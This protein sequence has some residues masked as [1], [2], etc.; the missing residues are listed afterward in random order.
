MRV[1]DTT[2]FIQAANVHTCNIK[3]IVQVVNKHAENTCPS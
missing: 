2:D 3:Y 1:N